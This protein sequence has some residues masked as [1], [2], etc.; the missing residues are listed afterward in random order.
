[1]RPGPAIIRLFA[2]SP[3]VSM[4]N[5]F[6]SYLL[7][8]TSRSVALARAIE[9]KHEGPSRFDLEHRGYVLGSIL[10]GVGFFEALANELFQDAFD[11]HDAPDSGV[12]GIGERA[13]LLMCEYWRATDLGRRGRTLDKFQTLLRLSAQPSLNPGESLYQDANLAIQLRNAIAHYRPED[14][15]ADEPA[16]MEAKLRG[17]FSDNKLMN[18]SGN[19]W[20]PDHCLGFGCAQWAIE[21]LVALADHVVGAIGARPNYIVHRANGWLGNVP[22]RPVDERS[23]QN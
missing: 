2:P 14:L 12:S 16:S 13:R 18:G 10:T 19:S 15:A 3:R 9:D 8:N 11:G 17:K 20:W 23:K 22:G 1:M 4:R 5:Y 6:S 7:A 21:S